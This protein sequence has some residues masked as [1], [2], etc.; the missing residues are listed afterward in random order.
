LVVGVAEPER[1]PADVFDD[2][3]VAFAAGVGQA[4]VDGG[5]DRLLPGVD[6]DG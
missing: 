5:D 4:G 3:V 1:D 6:G 2:A